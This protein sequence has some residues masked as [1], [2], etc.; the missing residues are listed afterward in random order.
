MSIHPKNL[1]GFK[2]VKQ[3]SDSDLGQMSQN[4]DE[5]HFRSGTRLCQGGRKS[6]YFFFLRSGQVEVFI[7]LKQGTQVLLTTLRPGDVFGQDIFVHGRNMSPIIKAKG[8][9]VAFALSRHVHGWSLE[10]KESW[11]VMVQ[12]LVCV[13]LVRQLR[14]A[15]DK[16]DTY[17]RNEYLTDVHQV[18]KSKPLVTPK[19]KIQPTEELP[20]LDGH[21]PETMQKLIALLAETESSL[22]P[23]KATPEDAANLES[24]N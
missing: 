24:N 10:Q 14:M 21:D 2:F 11:A 8:K 22:S 1:R 6:D 18:S 4:I 5:R 15:L 16:L 19:V 9:V 20:S 13:N 3:L 7:E 17:A 23:D 12:R